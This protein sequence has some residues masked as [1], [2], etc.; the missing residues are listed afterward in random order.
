MIE[1]PATDAAKMIADLNP[2]YPLLKDDHTNV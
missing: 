1:I 2:A